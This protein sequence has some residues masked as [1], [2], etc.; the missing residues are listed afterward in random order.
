MANFF[1]NLL[2]EETEPKEAKAEETDVPQNSEK[3]NSPKVAP[4]VVAPAAQHTQAAPAAVNYQTPVY[5]QVDENMK[6]KLLDEIEKSDLNG[7]DYLEFTRALTAMQ[8]IPMQENLK[9]QTVFATMSTQGLTKEYLLESAAHYLE[10]LNKENDIFHTDLEAHKQSTITGKQQLL[11]QQN[12][13]IVSMVEQINELQNKINEVK[14]AMVVTQQELG[15]EEAKIATL[16]SNFEATVLH[17]RGNIE[18][19]VQKMQSFIQ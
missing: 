19:D 11:E 2:F 18:S 12:E 14:Q 4:V 13:S 8:S 16:T 1:K 9:Y 7:P 15:E 6:T 5:P 17:V 10:V 3:G